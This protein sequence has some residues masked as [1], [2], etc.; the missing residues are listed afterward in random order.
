MLVIK[1]SKNL[2]D[3]MLDRPYIFA[4]VNKMFLTALIIFFLIIMSMRRKRKNLNLR[5]IKPRWKY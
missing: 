4:W 1:P 2:P 3:F 5:N